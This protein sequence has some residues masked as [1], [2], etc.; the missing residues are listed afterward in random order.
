MLDAQVLM[1]TLK[2][3]FLTKINSKTNWGK[4]EVAAIFL[5]SQNQAIIDSMR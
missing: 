5:E 3:I 2:D 4:N 1:T